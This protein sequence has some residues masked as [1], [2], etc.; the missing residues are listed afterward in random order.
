M[1]ADSPEEAASGA[2][3][4]QES[5]PEV[6][7]AKRELFAR[8]AE[9][10]PAHALLLSSSSAIPATRIA[11]E[12]PAET[13]ARVL[14]GH[15]FNPP[16]IMPL[17]EV[18]PGERTSA[19]ATEVAPALYR[20]YGRAPI[21]LRREV[22]GFVG[23]R[24]QNAVLREAVHLVQSGVVEVADLDTAVRNSLGLRWA[25]VGPLEGMHLGGGTG[26]LRA[27]MEHIGPSFAAIDVH[28]PDMSEAG[29]EPVITQ[30]EEAYG[31]PPEA[32][33]AEERDRVQEAILR[34]RA[35]G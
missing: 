16:H 2:D 3:F 22:R 6:P 7:A 30:A 10:A 21:R 28:E 32:R 23:N 9:A 35:E 27:F 14:I 8:L 29:T 11:E 20:A 33:I 1:R 24:L 5:G 17:V 34:L 31:L 19:A 26:G 15:P 12:L 4:V 13:A 18:V 25:A